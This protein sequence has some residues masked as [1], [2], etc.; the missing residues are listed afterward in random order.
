[1]I[2]LSAP[3]TST[4]ELLREWRVRRCV[5]VMA[6]LMAANKL[7]V[8]PAVMNHEAVSTLFARSADPGRVYWQA[9]E[10]RLATACDKLFVLRLPGWDESRGVRREIALFTELGRPITFVERAAGDDEEM[11]DE[12]RAS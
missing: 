12:G 6:E 11:P 2:Y 9:L 7:V 10:E 3:Y 8:C 4:D 1:M 5:M